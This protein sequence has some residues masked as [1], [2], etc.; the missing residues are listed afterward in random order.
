[1]QTDEKRF[2]DYIEEVEFLMRPVEEGG[3][4]LGRILLAR[5]LGI[6]PSRAQRWMIKV[7]SLQNGSDT[8]VMLEVVQLAQSKQKLQDK[9]RI[10]GKVFR[11]SARIGNSIEAYTKQLIDVITANQIHTT[12]E[13]QSENSSAVGIVHVSDAHFNELVDMCSN[14]YNFRVA[15]ARFK[16][17]ATKV[18]QCAEAFGITN[19]LLAMTGDMMN[20]DRRLD[21]LLSMTTNRTNA[22]FLAVDILQQFIVHLNSKCNVTVAYVTGNESRIQKDIGW[23]KMVATDNYDTTIFNILKYYFNNSD[24]IDFIDGDPREL[25]V[26]VAG[27]NILMIHGHGNVIKGDVEKSVEQIKGR[28]ASHGTNIDYVIF[29]HKHSA[30]IGDVFARAGSVVG[31]NAYSE[32]GLNLSSRASQNLYVVNEDGSLDGMKI[33]LQTYD[34]NDRYDIEES[35]ES[36]NPKSENKIV[37]HNTVFQVVV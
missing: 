12:T 5:E 11:E 25:V 7:A 22:T 17:L 31:G 30:C 18:L 29:G 13:F 9:N 16:K 20:S 27:K 28:Y 10:Q 34:E 15:S 26:N 32:M 2:E 21:E 19:L 37:D 36:Y 23:S 8:E 35:L 24:G 4:G 14:K 33:D 6:H 3:K 1:M